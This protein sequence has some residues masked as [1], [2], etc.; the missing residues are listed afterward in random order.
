[1]VTAER[2]TLLLRP[3]DGFSDS[4]DA[5]C[6]PLVRSPQAGRQWAAR[7]VTIRRGRWKLES[8][9]SV[10]SLSI[11]GAPAARVRAARGRLTR[12]RGLTI[13]SALALVLPLL[14]LTTSPATADTA[15]VPPVTLTTV[16]ADALPT[17]QINGVVWDQVVVGNTVYATGEF[18]SARP[19]GSP[20]GTNE[21]PRSNILAYNLT[22]GD[23]ITTWAPSLNAAGLRIVAS[24]D[25]SRIFVGGSFTQVN[26]VNR[27]RVVALDATT[28]AVIPNWNVVVNSRVHSLAISG[29]TL[30]LGGI[31]S[32]V[33][34][35]ARTRLAAVSAS[36]G[37]L[38]PWAPTADAEVL[39]LVAP[40]GSGRVI[41]AGKFASLNS[42][43]AYGTGA[44]DATTGALGQWTIGATVKNSGDNAAIYSLSTDG[45]QVYG[46][47]YT[48][49]S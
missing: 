15:P 41:A 11:V 35:Q 39:A 23:L 40:A 2:D 37:A 21:T 26:G 14:T 45:A 3:G 5:P 17:V 25:G 8:V 34:G 1:M 7:E 29:D 16:S 47:G 38:L 44:L 49:G 9:V 36:T 46:T 20:A 28:G 13:A 42:T 10:S 48:F 27:Y 4:R 24:P 22:T 30:Y 12:L 18:T 19:A 6:S 33:G 31:F 43:P 32:T